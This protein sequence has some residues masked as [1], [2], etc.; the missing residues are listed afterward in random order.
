MSMADPIYPPGKPGDQRLR[1]SRMNRSG[2]KATGAG[3]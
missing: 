2:T 1:R 3:A